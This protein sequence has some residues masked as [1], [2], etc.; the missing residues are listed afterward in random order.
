MGSGADDIHGGCVNH[1]RTVGV[2]GHKADGV[3]EQYYARLCA[4]W[5][6]VQETWA[7]YSVLNG[8]E[9]E[10]LLGK[11]KHLDVF[12]GR[13][14]PDAVLGIY[15]NVRESAVTPSLNKHLVIVGTRI[16][17]VQSGRLGKEELTLWIG[18]DWGYVVYD[19]ILVQ[20]YA[21]A[22]KWWIVYLVD[23]SSVGHIYG[24]RGGAGVL[25]QFYGFI[26][27]WSEQYLFKLC[28]VLPVDVMAWVDV[29]YKDIS[30]IGTGYLHVLKVSIW[31]CGDCGIT[32]IRNH[33]LVPDAVK[34]EQSP[35]GIGHKDNVVI[36]KMAHGDNLEFVCTFQ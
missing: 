34:E 2:Y 14:E 7:W 8:V 27:V 24:V 9:Q 10:F 1:E 12:I 30:V 15:R 22:L 29:E 3:G 21:A 36:C 4:E 35:V 20:V 6:S 31:G 18:V 25:Y 26:V 28:A 11:V 32:G 5:E 33:D 17:T 16:I 19:L 23:G 13:G